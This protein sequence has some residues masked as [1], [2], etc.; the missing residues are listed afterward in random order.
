MKKP[1]NIAQP[2]FGLVLAIVALT[3]SVSGQAVPPGDK[4]WSNVN[5][6]AAAYTVACDPSNPNIVYVGSHGTVFKSTDGGASWQTSALGGDA[7]VALVVDNA[8][9]NIIY[10]AIAFTSFCHHSY[11]RL[12]K[13]IDGG[14]SWSDSISPPI[15]GCDHIHALVLDPTDP[16]TL[17]LANFDNV[18]GDTFSPLVK[19]MNSGISWSSLFGPPFAALAID[20][21]QPRTIYGGTFD[22][23]YF[24]WEGEDPRN[25]V[26]KSTDGGVSFS[27]TGLTSTGVEA[28]A[29]DPINP[30]TLYAAT[31]GFY[32][33]PKGFRGLFKSIDGGASWSAINNGIDH[34]I[35]TDPGRSWPPTIARASLVIDPDNPSTLYVSLPG[36][37]VF[38]SGDGGANWAPFNDGLTN[39]DVR[40][41]AMA[42]GKPNTLYAAT[43]GGVF[44][45][46]DNTQPG[47]LIDNPTAFVRQ[48]YLDFLN[49]EPD[50]AGFAYWTNEITSCGA[51]LQCL[52][53]KRINVSAA[54]FLSIEFQ[55]TGYLVYRFYQAAYGRRIFERVPLTLEEFLPDTQQISQ[56]VIVTTPGWEDVLEANKQAFAAEFVTRPEFLMQYPLGLPAT[57][58]VDRLNANTSGALSQ[59]ERDALAS[60]L[61]NGSLSRAQVLRHV[62]EDGDPFSA[63]EGC[64]DYGRENQALD[65]AEDV[66][67]FQSEFN[68]AFVLMQYFG[69]L[70]RNPNQTPDVDFAGFDFW[71]S[72]LNQFNGNFVAAEMVKAFL[73]SQEYRQRFGGS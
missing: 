18:V 52:E 16:N 9:P 40:V 47:D 59:S 28:L 11:R 13:S 21:L 30:N 73:V 25:G 48:H 54:F 2:F 7:A 57:D 53:V 70:R 44:K 60:A 26:L 24:G 68:R 50:P 10:A 4:I 72:K 38:K 36:S 51:D 39:L 5:P 69:Y 23:T 31:R 27:L 71:L 65:T 1:S 32:S 17:Y 12:F 64:W 55:Q 22:F 14:A 63:C 66:N 37:G 19:S 42:P 15:N 3:L 46:I 43:S 34:L 41:L 58:F 20:P 67:L 33:E 35:G 62:A 6:G 61:A 49:R 56:G 45:V 29:I 8:N